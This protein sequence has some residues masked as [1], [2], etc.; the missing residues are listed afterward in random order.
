MM[1][2]LAVLNGRCYCAQMW[3]CC[4]E[5]QKKSALPPPDPFSPALHLPSGTCPL[6]FVVTC[7]RLFHNRQSPCRSILQGPSHSSSPRLSC[8]YGPCAAITFIL[9]DLPHRVARKPTE[10]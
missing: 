1:S 3:A 8:R 10:E 6:L 4:P 9:Q 2:L 7:A 5:H